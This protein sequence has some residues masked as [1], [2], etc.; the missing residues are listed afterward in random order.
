MMGLTCYS[1]FKEVQVPVDL[2]VIATPVRPL[3]KIIRE[4]VEAGV[5]AAVIL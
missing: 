3:P 4:C 2:A 1:S 5:G